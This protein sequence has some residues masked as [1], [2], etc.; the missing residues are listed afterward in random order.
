M[1]RTTTL[2]VLT[3]LAAVGGAP[4]RGDMIAPPPTRLKVAPADAVVVGKVTAVAEKAE[5]AEIYKGDERNLKI[6]TVKVASALMGKAGTTVKVGFVFNAGLP[7]RYPVAQLAKGQEALLILTKHPTKKGIYYLANYYDVVGKKDNA[8]FK[9]EVEEV[10]K[11][12]KLMASPQTG[13]KAKSAEDRLL[14]AA[15]LI[16][17]YKTP[18][19]GSDKT[20][21]VPPA[22]SK[23]LLTAL[24]EADWANPPGRDWQ[25]SPQNLFFR[26]GVTAKDGWTQPQDFRQIAPAAK[27]WLKDNAGKFKM[28]RYV[29][30]KVAVEPDPEP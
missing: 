8:A 20:E 17:R 21:A 7:R 10:K 5:K 23:L 4:A 30:D 11:V 29:R 25:L 2:V 18:P 16:T 6:A 22:E 27:K 28:T 24:A 3:L 14:T 12:V 26:L 13:L 9:N 15:L 1:T 19:P